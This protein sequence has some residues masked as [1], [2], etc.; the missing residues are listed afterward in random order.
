MHKKSQ[1]E[2]EISQIKRLKEEIKRLRKALH[3]C[4][5]DLKILL[6]RKGFCIY[7]KEPVADLVIPAKASMN[8]QFYE[9]LK[10]YSFRLFLRDVIKHQQFFRVEDVTRYATKEVTLK[11]IN[12]LIKAGLVG[13]IDEG[14]RLIRGPIKSFGETLEW[15]MARLLK[16]EFGAEV[17]WGVKF[18]RPKVGGDYDLIAKLDSSI[19]YVEI[20]SSPPKQIYDKEI[21]AFLNRV[22]DLSPEVSI[23]FLDTELRMKDKIVPMFEVELKRRYKR[24][25][26]VERM[27]RELFHINRK[28]FI[29]NSKESI[30][31]NLRTVLNFSLFR[32]KGIL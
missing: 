7:K 17:I 11:Y 26:P 13:Q 6:R 12:F 19:L 3:S 24:L 25:V 18:K 8:H 16:K 27:E 5:P 31:E 10:K 32:K 29:I 14:Y 23:F 28:V 20:K 1:Q 22:I 2:T 9:K 15:F 4:T 30:E 21:T